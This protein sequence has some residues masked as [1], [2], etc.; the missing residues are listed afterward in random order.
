[1]EYIVHR[2]KLRPGVDPQRFE[3][4]VRDVDYATCAVLPSVVTFSVQ[5]ASTDPE[6]PFHYFEIIGVRDRDAFAR[7]MKLDAFQGLEEVFGTMAV[8]VDEI[9]GT[10]VGPGYSQRSSW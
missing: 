4:W 7:D 8:V 10:R 9:A 3:S 2:I 1:M 5:R 6:A